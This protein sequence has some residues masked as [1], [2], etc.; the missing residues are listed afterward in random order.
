MLCSNRETATLSSCHHAYAGGCSRRCVATAAVSYPMSTV[1]PS[2]NLKMSVNSTETTSVL[3]HEVYLY[4]PGLRGLRANRR[5]ASQRRVGTSYSACLIATGKVPPHSAH[6]DLLPELQWRNTRGRDALGPGSRRWG[7]LL[8]DSNRL[9]SALQRASGCLRFYAAHQQQ[10][11]YRHAIG[12][13][14]CHAG[15]L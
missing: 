2:G 10:V 14:C 5:R 12:L 15:P 6:R 8:A 11:Q 13:P 1:L 7:R 4:M 3:S 9:D